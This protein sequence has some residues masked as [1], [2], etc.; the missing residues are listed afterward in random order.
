[1]SAGGDTKQGHEH[2]RKRVGSGA[3]NG[4]GG[5]GTGVKRALECGGTISA[6]VAPVP[7]ITFSNQIKIRNWQTHFTPE[8]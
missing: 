5:E 4:C 3:G 8:V 1:M 2:Q 7:T 6:H